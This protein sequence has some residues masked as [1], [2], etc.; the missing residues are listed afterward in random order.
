MSAQVKALDSFESKAVSQ[1]QESAAKLD[2]ELKDLKA[3]LSNIEEARPFDQLT[4]DDVVAAR[5][6]IGKTVEEM[7]KKGKWSLPGYTEKFGSTYPAKKCATNQASLSSKRRLFH[8]R[9][10]IMM[11]ARLS[12][13]HVTTG[14]VARPFC[15]TVSCA[16]NGGAVLNVS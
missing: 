6:E 14:Q 12:D 5:P 9:R 8:S 4:S 13:D 16:K 10:S 11:T 15:Y 7:V 3:T 1:A 2:G